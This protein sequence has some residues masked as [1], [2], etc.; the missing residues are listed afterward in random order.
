[1]IPATR[2]PS[3]SFKRLSARIRGLVGKA[4]TDFNMI[5]EGDRVMVCLSGGKDSY[6]LLDMLLSLQRAAPVSFELFAVNLD[7]KHPGFPAHVL[8]D[9]LQ[10]LGVPYHVIEQDTYAVVRRVI[11]AGRTQCGL[12]SRLRRGAL[13][14]Y[15]REQG[16]TRI[17][18]GHHRED[19]VETLFL[20]LFHGGRLKAMPPKL[21]SDDGANV[22]IRPL[23]YVPEREIARYARARQFP[24]IPCTLCGSQP[25]LQREAIA[26]ML[27][28]WDRAS[29]GRVDSIFTA[30]CNVEPAHLADPVAFDFATLERSPPAGP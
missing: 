5:G 21:R 28:E 25:N 9:Y 22:V 23:C 19:I 7:Q 2:E 16:F 13:Y 1:M 10:A 20:N 30:L 3:S 24:I 18:L 12:C 6:T 17:A 15:A 29:P 4:I 14:R 11:P 27:A 26:R 8:P